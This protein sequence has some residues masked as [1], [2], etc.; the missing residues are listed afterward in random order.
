MAKLPE[1]KSFWTSTITSADLGLTILNWKSICLL[2][3]NKVHLLDPVIITLLELLQTH[4]A[5]PRSVEYVEDISY[6]L[7]VKTRETCL[8]TSVLL[9]S[10]VSHTHKE[11]PQGS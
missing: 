1:M 2:S 3:D 5:V 10:Q 8:V 4:A 6:P 11:L 7:A 9:E